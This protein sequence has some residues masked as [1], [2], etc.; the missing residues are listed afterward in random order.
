M[1]LP[2]EADFFKVSSY[3]PSMNVHGI[4]SDHYTTVFEQVPTDMPLEETSNLTVS[5]K[6]LFTIHEISP[7]WG[8]AHESTKVSFFFFPFS[9]MWLV[10]CIFMSIQNSVMKF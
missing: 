2:E 9:I 7:E 4:N 1:L 8:Y 3:S 10:L 6:Q 5:Q